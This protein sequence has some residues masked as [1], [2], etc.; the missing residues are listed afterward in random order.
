MTST[1]TESTTPSICLYVKDG[2]LVAVCPKTN[3]YKYLTCSNNYNINEI[4]GSINLDAIKDKGEINIEGEIVFVSLDSTNSVKQLGWVE[5]AKHVLMRKD[6]YE[7]LLSSGESAE[8]LFYGI[9]SD[10]EIAIAKKECEGEK[11]KEFNSNV[12]ELVMPPWD[13][14]EYRIVC[15]NVK[16][17]AVCK[18]CDVWKYCTT[19][20]VVSK[21]DEDGYEKFIE[22]YL[23]N[24]PYPINQEC[25][26]VFY[27]TL[28]EN[29]SG[30]LVMD[31]ESGT[32]RYLRKPSYVQE[33]RALVIVNATMYRWLMDNRNSLKIYM[34]HLEQPIAEISLEAK[35]KKCTGDDESSSTD[36]LVA[37]I[38]D[39]VIMAICSREQIWKH[40][41]P[42][43]KCV[44]KTKESLKKVFGDISEYKRAIPIE[45]F[46][47]IL[48]DEDSAFIEEV[49]DKYV[50][51]DKHVFRLNSV[52]FEYYSD[53][54]GPEMINDSTHYTEVKYPTYDDTNII[55]I[56]MDNVFKDLSGAS[57]GK[58][59]YLNKLARKIKKIYVKTAELDLSYIRKKIETD[60]PERVITIKSI[61]YVIGAE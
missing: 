31:S 56:H 44:L 38:Y 20:S 16:F 17:L 15:D 35:L 61:K 32:G 21:T 13:N 19:T 45:P 9:P 46:H 43:S 12:R 27:M 55:A 5:D 25:E 18:K 39:D 8:E 49:V 42:T 1:S 60:Y 57:T 24:A 2:I 14:L 59:I 58:I 4:N 41:T 53:D 28:V 30:E 47:D 48:V 50:N 29:D 23:P 54:E 36:L 11:I 33:E 22:Q 10:E 37:V 52:M 40:T 7:I 6:N 51:P 3:A 34:Y 26:E